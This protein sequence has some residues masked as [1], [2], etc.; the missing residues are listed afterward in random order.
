[1]T[2]IPEKS[3]KSASKATC[4]AEMDRGMTMLEEVAGIGSP[5]P[6]PD[7][8]EYQ[9]TPEKRGWDE[10]LAAI[11]EGSTLIL[12]QAEHDRRTIAAIA[13]LYECHE[14]GWSYFLATKKIAIGR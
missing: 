3:V 5:I 8:L 1:M 12:G 10:F 7:F 13:G 6:F 14:G 9:E 2:D 4:V 11:V